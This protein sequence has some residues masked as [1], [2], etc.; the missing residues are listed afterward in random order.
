MSTGTEWSSET[1]PFWS[2]S[3]THETQTRPR[4]LSFGNS[5]AAFV[6]YLNE[7]TLCCS[8]HRYGISIYVCS[9]DVYVHRP[10]PSGIVYEFNG[11]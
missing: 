3:V 2:P 7:E 11:E 5:D 4:P 1:A 6:L 9:V 10:I 8:A